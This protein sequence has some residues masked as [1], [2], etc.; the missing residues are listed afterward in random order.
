VKLFQLAEIVLEFFLI[1]QGKMRKLLTFEKTV[2]T[3]KKFG[4]AISASALATLFGVSRGFGMLADPPLLLLYSTPLRLCRN[5]PKTEK[6][7]VPNGCSTVQRLVRMRL[8]SA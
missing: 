1:A 5:S 6:T 7:I 4:S 3:E 2:G 8:G